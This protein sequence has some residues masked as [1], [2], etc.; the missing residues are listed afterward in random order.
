M[1]GARG[2]GRV[3]AANPADVSEGGI[4]ATKNYAADRI[5]YKTYIMLDDISSISSSIKLR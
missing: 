5:E 1:E 4:H 3:V 2:S